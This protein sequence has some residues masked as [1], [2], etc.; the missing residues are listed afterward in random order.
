MDF[1]EVLGIV[2]GVFTSA[3]LLPQ[4]IKILKEKKVEDLSVTMFVSLMIGVLLWI[5]YGVFKK[6]FPI[7]V[8]NS[9]SVLLNLFILILR[10]KYKKGK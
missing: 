5:V 2:A 1:T 10:A 8:T 9:F 6:D 7:I 3:S 4:V